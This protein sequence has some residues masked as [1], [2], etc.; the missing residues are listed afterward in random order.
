[1]LKS[2]HDS[3]KTQFNSG[4]ESMLEEKDAAMTRLRNDLNAKDFRIQ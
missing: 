1:M 2:N 3:N 4:L